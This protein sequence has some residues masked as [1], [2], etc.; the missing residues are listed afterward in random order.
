MGVIKSGIIGPIRKKVGP[1]VNRV[2]RKTNVVTA[3]YRTSNKPPTAKQLNEQ[4]KFSLLNSFLSNIEELVKP[5]FKK[6]ANSKT[7]INA[8]YKFNFPH[9]F[10]VTEDQ[11]SL[12]LPEIMYSRGRIAT[13]DDTELI[14]TNNLIQ[15]NWAQQSQNPSCQFSDRA[16]FLLY[17]QEKEQSLQF[18]DVADR[19]DREYNVKIPIDFKGDTLHCYM[20][21]ASADGKL[22]GDS[23][24]IGIIIP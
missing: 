23:V 19:Y 10:L 24:Y 5:G 4:A 22:A 9:A 15:F 2:H 6:Y 12:N 8:A 14:L 7:E 16:S 1:S 11:I 18:I 13:P 21:F 20:S 17:N 3:T